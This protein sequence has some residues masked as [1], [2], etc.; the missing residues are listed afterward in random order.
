[1]LKIARSKIGCRIAKKLLQCYRGPSVQKT[2]DDIVREYLDN[3]IDLC[4]DIYGNF[5]I[6][7]MF[8]WGNE[9]EVALLMK[10]LTEN[11]GK[12]PTDKETNYQCVYAVLHEALRCED[13]NA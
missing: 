13:S 10:L 3:A 1:M 9:A 7:H 11:L 6:Q 5:V 12:M 2:R 8:K 4:V